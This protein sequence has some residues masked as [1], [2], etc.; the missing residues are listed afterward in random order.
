MTRYNMQRYYRYVLIF[1]IGQLFL[2]CN[3][4]DLE[5]LEKYGYI[6]LSPSAE[7]DELLYD[8]ITVTVYDEDSVLVV[9]YE[10][11]SG[12]PE[13]IEL[14][15]GNYY[16]I[17]KS[18]ALLE[19]ALGVEIYLESGLFSITQDLVV[20]ISL[21]LEA[22]AIPPE[23]G[24]EEICDLITFSQNYGG[25]NRDDGFD[26]VEK[27]DGGFYAV[28]RSLSNNTDLTENKGNWDV[29]AYSTDAEGNLLWQHSLGGSS[30]DYGEAVVNGNDGGAVIAARSRST[31]GDRSGFYGGWDYWIIKLDDETGEIEW[32]QHF[33][34][35]STDYALDIANSVDGDG[36]FVAGITCS[37]NFDV[38]GAKGGCDIWV[39]KIDNS[40]NLV[41]EK[42]VGGTGQEWAY[43][44]DATSDGGCVVGGQ[45]LSNNQDFTGSQGGWDYAAAKLDANGNLEWSSRWGG[46]NV[47][48]AYD[49]Q[50]TANG[51]YIMCGRSRSSNGDVVGGNGNYDYWVLRI[52]ANG[53]MLWQH[54]VGGTSN[55]Y[56][57]GLVEDDE[58]DIWVNGRSASGNSGDKTDHLGGWDYWLVRLDGPTG[59][60][61]STKS[62]GGSSTDFGYSISPTCDKGFILNGWSLS[63]DGDV[64]GVY[65]SYDFWLVKIDEN[66]EF[67]P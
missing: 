23:E 24:E 16:L 5:E 18:N 60:I 25:T 35:S 26:A 34:G 43:G 53:N 57:E 50:Q 63:S 32:E 42:I 7:F 10:S 65:G 27:P 17:V 64:G 54:P 36:Y 44:V 12:A 28:G 55:D 48:Q 47:D 41:W 4:D 33:G 46:T 61:I 1:L 37:G 19:G 6:S 29:W 2:G 52:D 58:G 30:T 40:G 21:P 39:I 38:T 59:D 11:I 56:G 9:F 15:V 45:T 31:N 13:Q 49:I 22:V 67:A 66:G 14:P 51:E 8:N 3:P 20:T 62:F